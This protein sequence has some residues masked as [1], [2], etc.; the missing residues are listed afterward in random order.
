MELTQHNPNN[1][2]IISY[3]KSNIILQHTKL[4]KPCFISATTAKKIKIK[5]LADINKDFI[6]TIIAKEL[7]DLIIIGTGEMVSF[8]DDKEMVEIVNLGVGIEC[9]NNKSALSS[10]NILLSDSRAVGL[11][12]LC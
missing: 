4:E 8:L 5:S 11:I 1:N 12:A 10:F 6:A 2:S 9:M 7:L 3:D